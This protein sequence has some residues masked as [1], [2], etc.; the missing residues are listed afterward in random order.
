[1]KLN[2]EIKS[3]KSN[4]QIRKEEKD[5]LGSSRKENKY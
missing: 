5:L 3:L 1:M 4:E 2:I